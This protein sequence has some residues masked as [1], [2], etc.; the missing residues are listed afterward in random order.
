[1]ENEL[2][3]KMYSFTLDAV[4]PRGL[5]EFYAK[6]LG[7]DIVP[8][9]DDEFV[10]IAPTGAG[11]GSYPGVTFQKNPEYA[12]PVWPEEPGRQQQMAHIDFAVNDVDKAVEHA[13]ELGAT[14]AGSQFSEGWKV[15]LDPEGHPFCLCKGNHVFESPDFALR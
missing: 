4:D 1:M 3:I 7:W 10:V 12:P 9:P 14:V 13:V 6:L 2:S 8:F 11:L 5:A 15:M